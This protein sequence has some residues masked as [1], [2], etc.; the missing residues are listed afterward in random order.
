MPSGEVG[1]RALRDY[2]SREIAGMSARIIREYVRE[3]F[4]EPAVQRL[5]DI[6]MGEQTF[7]VLTKD[8]T[9]KEIEASPRVQV[10]ALSTLIAIGIPGQLGLVDDDGNALPGVIA[11]GELD[12]ASA[13]DASTGSRF[14]AAARVIGAP[15]PTDAPDESPLSPEMQ[16][17]IEAGEF[18]VVEVEEGTAAPRALADA[19]PPP[20]DPS[21]MTP[22]QVILAKRRARRNGTNGNGT[23][24]NGANGN[25][26]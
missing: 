18:Q 10:Q 24:G 11:L 21:V 5:Y 19:P 3:V 8:G 22:E 26:R 16:A 2:M 17:R 9:I 4:I 6:G 7:E 1:Q 14:G 20:I 23:N 15:V 25:G 12:M 13:R